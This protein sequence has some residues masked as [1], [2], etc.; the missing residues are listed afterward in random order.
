[1][2]DSVVARGPCVLHV[3]RVGFIGGAERI[4]LT[5]LAGLHKKNWEPVLAC[6][7]GNFPEEAR[8][9]SVRYV[10]CSWNR[11]RGTYNPLRLLGYIA[12]VWRAH[13]QIETILVGGTVDLV[14]AH[15]PVMVLY[16]CSSCRRHK[17]PLLLHLHEGPPGRIFDL[18][19]LKVAA[20]FADRIVCAS[21]AGLDL[22]RN[23]GGDPAKAQVVKNAVDYDFTRAEVVPCEDARGPGPHIGIFGVLEPRKGQNYLIDAVPLLIDVY[24]D[25]KFWIVGGPQFEDKVS[26]A[27]HL[28]SLA[29]ARGVSEHLRFVGHQHN[30]ERWMKAMDLVVLPSVSNESLSVVVLE[31]LYLGISVVATDV[32]GIR[33]ALKDGETGFI[34]EPRS[35]VALARAM[36]TALTENGGAMTRR[37]REDAWERFAPDRL[38]VDMIAVYRRMI[39][40]R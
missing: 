35:A 33:D 27:Q 18:I 7:D 10:P 5:I 22:L 34:V 16:A 3:A 21:S 19:A 2:N 26:Y 12:E 24:P 9:R 28:V 32:G 14:H 1:M 13:R 29:Q 31:A 38:V 23:A 4:A 17:V 15:H 6:P 30:V 8:R 40:D 36:T 39:A 11:M 25:A 20:R 37:A